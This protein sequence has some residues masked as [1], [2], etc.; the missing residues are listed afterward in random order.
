MGCEFGT[1]WKKYGEIRLCVDLKNL[2]HALD[3]DIYPVL[4]MEKILQMVS[5]SEL[6]SL[7]YGFSGYNQVLVAE[8]DRLETTFR[9]KWG[10][11][12]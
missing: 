8:Q 12:T 4:P 2:N 6:L 11:F 5:G 3:K 7:L 9:T 1:I 10:N